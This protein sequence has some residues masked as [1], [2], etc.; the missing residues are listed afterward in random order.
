MIEDNQ[1]EKEKKG[2][3]IGVKSFVTAIG[4]IFLLMILILSLC[5][6]QVA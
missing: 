4:I 6:Q 2:L 3:D 5:H 1:T